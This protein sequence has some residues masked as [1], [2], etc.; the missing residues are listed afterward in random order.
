[1]GYTYADT[2]TVQAHGRVCTLTQMISLRESL[3]F[4]RDSSS[5]CLDDECIY[6]PVKGDV[7]VIYRNSR[8][9]G[10]REEGL[11]STSLSPPAILGDR[12]RDLFTASLEKKRQTMED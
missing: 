2:H 8:P 5:L 1:M 7:C 9:G 3:R 4:A 6:D 12:R 10:G 11:Y